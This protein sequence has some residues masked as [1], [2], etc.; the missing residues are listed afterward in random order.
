MENRGA[1]WKASE[2]DRKR[3]MPFSGSWQLREEGKTWLS[4]NAVRPKPEV[5]L[6]QMFSETFTQSAP[7][8]PSEKGRSLVGWPRRSERCFSSTRFRRSPWLCW[9]SSRC[10]GPQGSSPFI[11]GFLLPVRLLA[12]SSWLS[13][14]PSVPEWIQDAAKQNLRSCSVR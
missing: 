11:L 5:S 12:G 14:N 8:V 9:T 4:L 6:W 7:F 13:G 1:A 10:E 2:M 3:G